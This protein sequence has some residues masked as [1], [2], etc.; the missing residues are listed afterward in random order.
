[1]KIPANTTA[2]VVLPDKSIKKVGSGTYNFKLRRQN[3]N[4]AFMIEKE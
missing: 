3:E 4:C 1:V 2:D